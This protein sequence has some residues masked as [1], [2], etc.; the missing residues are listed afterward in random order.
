[1]RATRV[2]GELSI[3]D[4]IDDEAWSGEPITDFFPAGDVRG[5]P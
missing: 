3:D 2:R 1:M 4:R 5:H